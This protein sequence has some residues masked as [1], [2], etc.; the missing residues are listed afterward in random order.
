MEEHIIKKLLFICALCV[1][2]ASIFATEPGGQLPAEVGF[3]GFVWGTSMKDFTAKAGNPVHRDEI[4]G[5][6]SLVYDNL[7]QDGYQAFMV[8][9]FSNNGL[10]G[11][12]YYF[13]TFTMEELTQCYTNMQKSLVDKFGSTFLCLPMMKEPYLYESVWMLDT[14]YIR[15]KVD[16]RQNDPVSLWF[17]S[18]ALTNRLGIARASFSD[19]SRTN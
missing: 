2:T 9:Y 12:T 11:G 4:N 7:L 6:Q 3:H 14:G 19:R 1:I 15:L 17:S 13:N 18:P 8:V 5:L 16:T 10:E